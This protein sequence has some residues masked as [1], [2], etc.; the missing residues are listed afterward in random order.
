MSAQF[1]VRGI[2]QTDYDAWRPLWDGYNAFYGRYGASALP[3]EI[4]QATW[5]RFFDP[6][7]PVNAMV[8]EQ[9]GHLI[10]L[11]HYIYHRSTTRLNGICYLQD[12]FTA[13]HA[14]GRGVGRRLIEAVYEAARNAGS[15]RVYWQT[16]AGNQAGRALYDKVAKHFGFIVYSYEL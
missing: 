11:V 8:A 16:Q 14:R 12:L 3:D 10:G 1:M 15:S 4:T 13:E 5:G 6:S 9:T 7:E 2:Q